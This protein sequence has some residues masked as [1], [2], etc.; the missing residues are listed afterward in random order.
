MPDEKEREEAFRTETCP[1][2]PRSLLVMLLKASALANMRKPNLTLN[3]VEEV[4][5][6]ALTSC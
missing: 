4:L 6:L 2:Q 3:L 5:A 1:F